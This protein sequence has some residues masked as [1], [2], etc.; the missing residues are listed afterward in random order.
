[1]DG[2]VDNKTDIANFDKGVNHDTQGR[3]TSTNGPTAPGVYAGTESRAGQ[4]PGADGQ[5]LGRTE[6]DRK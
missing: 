2:S 3:N 1:M 4:A 6:G 5:T